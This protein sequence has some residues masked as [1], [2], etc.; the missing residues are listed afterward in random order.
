M[1]FDFFFLLL[2]LGERTGLDGA[3]ASQLSMLG[4]S[5]VADEAFVLLPLALLVIVKGP[6]EA[7]GVVL[8][9]LAGK[10]DASFISPSPIFDFFFFPLEVVETVRGSAEARGILLAFRG[11][12]GI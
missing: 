3:L 4:G 10:A 6:S 5:A 2:A 1:E 7:R 12:T 9:F 11:A 8:A